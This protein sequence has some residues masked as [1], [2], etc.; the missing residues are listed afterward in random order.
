MS[1]RRLLQ[2]AILI[3]A[4]LTASPRTHAAAP[5]VASPA[6]TDHDGLNDLLE[7]TLLEQFAPAFFVGSHDCSNLPAAFAPNTP[8][9]TVQQEDGTIYGEA[10]PSRTSTPE[11]PEVELHYYHLWNRDCGE[12]GHPL[13]AEHVSVLLRAS[14]PTLQSAKWHALYW[15]AAAHENTV[16][17]VS[18]IARASTLHAVDRGAKVWISPDKHA[19]YLNETLCRG[20]C[21]ADRCESM[22][23]LKAARI[24]N[25]GEPAHPM[26][27][28]TFTASTAWPL[29]AKMRSTNFPPRP[30]ARLN[31]LPESDI[32][33]FSAGRHPTRQIIAVSS[34]TEG[35]LALSGSNTTAA[36]SV[37][38][39]STGGALGTGYRKTRHALGTSV[40]HTGKALH[41]IPEA[42]PRH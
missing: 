8:A 11:A 24:I 26:N 23:P 25:L 27:A 12:H 35:A 28:S 40:R 5:P 3:A 42:P 22:T 38:G 16:C 1:H 29:A 18:Q 7:Q 37:A 4:L 30:L 14:E 36:I 20:G 39:N 33:W 41:L 13:D 19:S 17:D 34:T 6:D 10:F 31:A 21:G 2:A 32:A 9:P 15:Y